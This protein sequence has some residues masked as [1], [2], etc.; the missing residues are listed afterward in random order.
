[1]GEIGIPRHEFLY[2][3]SYW[4]VLRIIRGYRR[5][6]RLRDQLIAEAVFA[7]MHTIRDS[8]GKTVKDFFPMLFEDPDDDDR[9][10]AEPLS[11]E[12]YA[13]EQ[14]LM[15]NFNFGQPAPPKEAAPAKPTAQPSEPTQA[16]D[17]S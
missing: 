11:E 13:Y 1:V 6:G 12:G 4:E 3:L 16:P 2:E 17:E 15:D 14:A 9:E 7:A 8:K 5:R 10:P